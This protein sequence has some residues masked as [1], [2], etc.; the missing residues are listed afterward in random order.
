MNMPNP[1]NML[2]GSLQ[3]FAGNNPILNNV[4][5]KV[6]HN[7]TGDIEQ[8]ARNLCKERGIDADAMF[9]EIQQK[10]NRR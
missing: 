2:F 10:M 7:Q 4:L 5:D 1:F 8:I 9:R 6:S 3:N